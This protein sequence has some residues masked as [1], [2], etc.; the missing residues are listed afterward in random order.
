MINRGNYTKRSVENKLR[1]K[2][3]IGGNDQKRHRRNKFINHN[4]YTTHV[5]RDNEEAYMLYSV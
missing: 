4:T 2:A 5:N 3:L 1:R